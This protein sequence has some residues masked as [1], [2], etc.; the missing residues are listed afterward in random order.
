MLA[1][2]QPLWVSDS[3]AQFWRL[4]VTKEFTKPKYYIGQ[5]VL[6]RMKKRNGEILHPVHIIGLWWTRYNWMYCIKLPE[7][8]PEWIFEDHEWIEVEESQ[9]E[10]M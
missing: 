9:I 2:N 8:H 6:H 7:D 3:R 4:R 1:S 5:T 10:E